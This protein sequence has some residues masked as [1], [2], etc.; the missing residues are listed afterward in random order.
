[1]PLIQFFKPGSHMDSYVVALNYASP[2]NVLRQ[3]QKRQ[4]KSQSLS[5]LGWAPRRCHNPAQAMDSGN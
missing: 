3:D 4:A 1:M 2:Q 5:F